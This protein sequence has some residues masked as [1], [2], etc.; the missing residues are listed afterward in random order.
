MRRPLPLLAALTL[1]AIVVGVAAAPSPRGP[2]LAGVAR[3]Y[4]VIFL[5]EVSY[6]SAYTGILRQ[7]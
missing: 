7:A 3:S 6:G 2:G 5:R 4:H 1:F